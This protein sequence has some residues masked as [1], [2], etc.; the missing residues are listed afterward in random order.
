MA[1]KTTKSVG[2]DYNK[3]LA[4]STKK[5]TDFAESLG[6]NEEDARVA[7]DRLRKINLD[8]AAEKAVKEKA[9]K[10]GIQADIEA[11]DARLKSLGV[12]RSFTKGEL[13]QVETARKQA[14]GNRRGEVFGV[15]GLYHKVARSNFAAAAKVKIDVI[16][17]QMAGDK[18]NL[19]ENKEDVKALEKAIINS[20]TIGKNG[21]PGSDEQQ[22]K[23]FELREKQIKLTKDVNDQENM[24]DRLKLIK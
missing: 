23:M 22:K 2:T 21:Q 14:Y 9:K 20:R 3:K 5:K 4:E 19:K 6:H 7:N 1:Y 12:D 17:K 24:I 11:S 13:T 18:E 15:S 10:A 8:I 16:E